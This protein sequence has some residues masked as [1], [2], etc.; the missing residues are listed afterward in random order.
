[1]IK[2]TLR[3]VATLAAAVATVATGTALTTAPAQAATTSSVSSAAT[4]AISNTLL[5]G[6]RLLSGQYIR[7]TD[8][9]WTLVMR[10]TGNVELVRTGTGRVWETGT[11]RAGSVLVMEKDG[12][13]SIVHGRTKYWIGGAKAS[14]NAKL[15]LPT[16]GLLTIQNTAGRSVWNYKMIIET[17]SPGSRIYS[18]GGSWGPVVLFSRSRVY[19][20]QMR[21]T[22]AL[23]L[24]QNNKTVLW[25]A[26][27]KPFV[28]YWAFLSP[29][30]TFGVE[31]TFGSPWAIV[32]KKPGTV[33]QLRDDGKLLLI[34]GRTVVKALH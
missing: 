25:T 28:D 31:E 18:P 11:A 29:A 15:V 23:Q 16:D 6:Q 17:M 3:S 20:L 34:H 5:P 12:G 33:L 27:Y 21:P 32:T 19:S 8:R 26:P 7:S 1:M 30:G 22:G 13:L 14:P 24:L 4:T 2:T 9:Q 10:A